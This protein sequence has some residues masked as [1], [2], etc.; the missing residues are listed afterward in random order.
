MVDAFSNPTTQTGPMAFGHWQGTQ[1]T[2]DRPFIILPPTDRRKDINPSER[3]AMALL[4]Q[5][6]AEQTGAGGVLVS[7]ANMVGAMRPQADT[8]DR[9]LDRDMEVLFN[10]HAYDKDLFDVS[11]IHTLESIQSEM[12]YLLFLQGD[13]FTA[14]AESPS[15]AT[16]VQGF[17]GLDCSGGG[18]GWRDGVMRNSQNR[19]EAYNFTWVTNEFKK[20][21]R[22]LP[23]DAIYHHWEPRGYG[24]SRGMTALKHALGRLQDMSYLEQLAIAAMKNSTIFALTADGNE[25]RPGSLA[26]G[27]LAQWPKDAILTEAQAQAQVQAQQAQPPEAVAA[28][29]SWKL[30]EATGLVSPRPLKAVQSVHP[31]P[32][33]EEFKKWILRMIAVP[34]G[35]SPALL[36]HI[37]E[38]PGTWSRIVLDQASRVMKRLQGRHLAPFILWHWRRFFARAFQTGLMKRPNASATWWEAKML[39]PRD[40]TADYGRVTAAMGDM[41]QRGFMS[42]DSFAGFHNE[43]NGE[44]LLV[45][46]AATMKRAR[47]LEIENDL[48]PGDLTAGL[49]PSGVATKREGTETSE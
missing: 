35:I 20:E 36:F 41:V 1:F 48:Q 43:G 13:C 17:N 29:T 24:N 23:A 19:A 31:T 37:D 9:G 10:A 46:R 3:V 28:A 4:A 47:E 42:L 14:S 15:G 38:P 39:S 26:V 7:L 30:L 12:L 33:A 8:G 34:L 2:K 16:W 18:K 6:L 40:L 45:A 22:V 25:D 32:E 44:D 49:L 21:S 11:G 5:V 27:G